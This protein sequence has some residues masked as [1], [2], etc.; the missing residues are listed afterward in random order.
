MIGLP[1][2]LGERIRRLAP[3]AT[4]AELAELVE[5]LAVVAGGQLVVEVEDWLEGRDGPP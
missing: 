4:D 3:Y 1:E 5:L 2:G